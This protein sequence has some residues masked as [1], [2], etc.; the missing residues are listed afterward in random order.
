MLIGLMYIIYLFIL[1]VLG[2]M[3]PY[4]TQSLIPAGDAAYVLA[5]NYVWNILVDD[6]PIES[7]LFLGLMKVIL[8]I[9]A[10]M[11]QLTDC[12]P[13]MHKIEYLSLVR[14]RFTFKF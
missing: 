9:A 8:E 2:K 6:M 4:E 5:G 3:I 14:D 10:V 13:L 7:K 1:L 11:V 12:W